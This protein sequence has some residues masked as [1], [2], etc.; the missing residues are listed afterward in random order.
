M[1]CH[2]RRYDV[3]R[4]GI[5]PAQTLSIPIVANQQF[6]DAVIAHFQLGER[7]TQSELDEPARLDAALSRLQARAEHYRQQDKLLVDGQG[8]MRLTALLRKRP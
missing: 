2:R 1:T 8:L 5:G 3:E 7:M 6:N 4:H